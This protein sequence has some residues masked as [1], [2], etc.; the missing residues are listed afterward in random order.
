VA[1]SLTRS[2]CEPALALNKCRCP[3]AATTVLRCLSRRSRLARHLTISRKKCEKASVLE[4]SSARRRRVLLGFTMVAVAWLAIK[5]TAEPDVS[6]DVLSYTALLLDAPGK[7][8]A[9]LHREAYETVARSVSEGEYA[10]LT[11]TSPYRT[12]T[13]TDPRFFYREIEGYRHRPLYIAAARFARAVFGLGPFEAIFFVSRATFVAFSLVFAWVASRVLSPPFAVLLSLGVPLSA[14][15][16]EAARLASPDM[17][18]TLALFLAV[19]SLLRRRISEFVAFGIA[20]AAMR[21]EHLLLLLPIACHLIVSEPKEVERR[22][23]WTVAIGLS[24]GLLGVAFFA[25]SQA[26]GF[27]GLAHLRHSLVERTLDADALRLPISPGEYLT[28]LWRGLWGGY[29]YRPPH[30]LTALLLA[31]GALW[32]LRP[33]GARSEADAALSQRL[34]RTIWLLLGSA[35]GLALLH[36]QLIDRYY[37]P[38]LSLLG[39]LVPLAFADGLALGGPFAMVTPVPSDAARSAAK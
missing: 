25:R 34:Y 18:A 13:A 1:A 24:V 37:L 12:A 15:F 30:L 14:P 16:L 17:I 6:W 5:T 33:S 11:K 35:I 38:H 8:V 28:A 31:L 26:H 10:E 4:S 7:S 2:R 9:D 20:V 36:P 21:P 39:L 27:S 29:S 19:W 32:K 22:R 3:S 23:A